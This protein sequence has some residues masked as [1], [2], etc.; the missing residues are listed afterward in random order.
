LT[1]YRVDASVSATNQA[2][3]DKLTDLLKARRAELLEEYKALKAEQQRISMQ[4]PTSQAKGN[5]PSVN[6]QINAV[7]QKMKEFAKTRKR[8]NDAVNSVNE[9]LGQNVQTLPGP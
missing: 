2:E 1:P 9:I 8:F 7:N 4:R 5:P 3:I 6:E